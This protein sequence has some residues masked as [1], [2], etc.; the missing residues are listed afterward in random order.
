[1][2]I[3]RRCSFSPGRIFADTKRGWASKNSLS[4]PI[5]DYFQLLKFQPVGA[6]V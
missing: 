5:A 3:A 4:L 1:M 6:S 2:V